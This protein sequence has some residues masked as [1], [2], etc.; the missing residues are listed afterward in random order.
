MS[1]IFPKPNELAE[2]TQI[3]LKIQGIGPV[4]S[5]KNTKSLFKNKKT[6][7]LFVA[8]N[9]VKK[10]WMQSAEE[11]IGLQLLFYYQTIGA[12][13][14]QECLKRLQ[15]FLSD[16]VDDSVRELPE[17][18]WKVEYVEPGKEGCEILIERIQ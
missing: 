6:G 12:E 13:T 1:K 9:P 5:F 18:G 8:T 14:R 17:G 2:P 11:L 15:T 10:R 4:P 7:K 16:L 3:T